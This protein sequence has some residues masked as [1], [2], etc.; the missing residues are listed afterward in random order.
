MASERKPK[1]N[2]PKANIDDIPEELLA[3]GSAR[4]GQKQ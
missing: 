4:I 3:E 2:E 1:K